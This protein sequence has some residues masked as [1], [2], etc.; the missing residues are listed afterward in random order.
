MEN[1]RVRKGLFGTC[2]LQ[3]LST[4][5]E[6]PGHDAGYEWV[7]VKYSEAPRALVSEM[8]SLEKIR[9]LEIENGILEGLSK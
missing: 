2:V 4:W 3:R 6:I 8:D 1:F 9:D 7:D 5:P